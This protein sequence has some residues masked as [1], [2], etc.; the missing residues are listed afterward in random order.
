MN[1]NPCELKRDDLKN[2]IDEYL[3]L[4]NELNMKGVPKSNTHELLEKRKLALMKIHVTS[5][6]LIDCMQGFFPL[7]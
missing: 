7:K 4:E 5:K 1:D 6:D 3:R 2:A